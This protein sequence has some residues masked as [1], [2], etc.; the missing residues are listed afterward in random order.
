MQPARRLSAIETF[1]LGWDQMFLVE[2]IPGTRVT[3]INR[4]LPDRGEQAEMLLA[5]GQGIR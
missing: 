1:N 5:M 3:V 4:D 2:E